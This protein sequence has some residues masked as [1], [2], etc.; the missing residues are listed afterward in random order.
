VLSATT[1]E[2]VA[3]HH[4]GF[5]GDSL[6]RG[7]HNSGVRASLIKSALAGIGL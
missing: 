1:H 6:G 3:L 2:V 5:G 4:Y 7:T